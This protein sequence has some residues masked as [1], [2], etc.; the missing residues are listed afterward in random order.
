MRLREGEDQTKPSKER[1]ILGPWSGLRDAERGIYTNPD[2]SAV[3][4]EPLDSGCVPKVWQKNF[5]TYKALQTSDGV[6]IIEDDRL[7]GGIEA[8]CTHAGIPFEGQGLGAAAHGAL[9]AA[10]IIGPHLCQVE[11]RDCR[12]TG[13]NVPPVRGAVW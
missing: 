9:E 2:L 4:R 3:R 8:F 1:G 11:A 12:K 7:R 6:T 5:H 10:S 13:W